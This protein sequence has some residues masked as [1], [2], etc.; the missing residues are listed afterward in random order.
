MT[1]SFKYTMAT[2][3]AICLAALLTA[4]ATAQ[5]ASASVASADTPAAQP[6]AT[7]EAAQLPTGPALETNPAIKAVL[8]TPRQTPAEFFQAVIWLVQFDRPD[9]A[10][11]IF[12]E[13]AK[14][15]LT[16]EQRIELVSKF[17]SRDMLQLAQA[18]ALA[19]AGQQFADACMKAAAAA[20]NDP[21]R[22]AKL[23]A[24]LSDPSAE[25]RLMARNDLAATGQPGI[26]A[27]L[28]AL[29][30]EKDVSRRA[31]LEAAATTMSPLVVGPLLAMQ[32]S[33]DPTTRATADRL[34]QELAVQQAAPLIPRDPHASEA[35]LR[36]AI[37]HYRQGMLPFALD[38]QNQ[39][40]LWK[41]D[42]KTKKLSAA[43]YPADE[44][45]TM[46]MARLA[47]QL[48]DLVPQ[49]E[50]YEKQ[51]LLLE[52]EAAALVGDANSSAFTK[53]QAVD[54]SLIDSL[55]A[56]AL[57]A[58][59]E[60]AATAAIQVLGDRR[61]MGVLYTVDSQPSPLANALRSPNRRVR[62]AALRAIMAIDPTSPYPGS[63]RVPE[64]VAWFAAGTNDRKAVVA[65]PNMVA[66]TNLAG[67]LAT[68]G[69]N[70]I[71]VET[72][73]E[74]VDLALKTPDLEAIFVDVNV[75][76]PDIRQTVYE[77]R[78]SPTT[79][80]VPI[81]IVA[82]SSRLA[83]AER[84]AAEH[85]RVIAVPRI[86]SPEVLTRVVDR[87]AA[88]SGRFV[89]TPAERS[90][91]SVEALSWFSKLAA[92]TR[93]FY[94]LRR[95]E[96]VLEAALYN[97]SGGESAIAALGKLS[98]PR[99]QRALVNF[100]SQPTLPIVSRKLAANAFRENVSLHGVLLT[101]AEILAQ[102][103]RYNASE[104]ADAETQQVLG[105]VLD[106]IESPRR[107]TA[108]LPL[109]FHP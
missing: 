92:G 31:A 24:E 23:V 4:P 74:A 80:H 104:T 58:H 99:A 1:Q 75:N 86:H 46:W 62:F 37:E 55:L 106:V 51:A 97:P 41:W 27:L 32:A 16:D 65:M 83:A 39:I 60:H 95:N 19:P 108:D 101:S 102:Y 49:N 57:E 91:E 14:M 53:L 47:R 109:P 36:R 71:G 70:A 8:E 50:A 17:G 33:N 52:L 44:A 21:E 38:D 45:R 43:K 96:P 87:L 26:A 89:T 42:D 13:L 78:I 48:A 90:M 66:S 6:T 84:I 81:A 68:N 54:S 29:A 82:P 35:A 22:I 100:A 61:D 20:A 107:V 18:K 103:D 56:D 25:V 3:A 105:S 69:L 64:A 5:S 79:A 94:K 72:G 40:E 67:M 9:L 98:D 2:L 10:K 11:P 12:D 28:E 34:L 88:T 93:P 59:F 30:K 73:R 77:L 7:P 15:P 63:S 76:S 85:T